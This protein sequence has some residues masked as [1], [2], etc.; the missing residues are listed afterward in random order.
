VL[1]VIE[2]HDSAFKAHRLIQRTGDTTAGEQRARELIRRLDGHLGLYLSFYWCDN[3]TGNKTAEHY[4]WFRRQCSLVP[5]ALPL[6]PTM[7]S[8]I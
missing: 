3:N 6:I 7:I 1:E 8:G 2:L 5:E 4:E